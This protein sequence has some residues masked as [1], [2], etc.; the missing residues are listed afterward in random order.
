MIYMADFVDTLKKGVEKTIDGAE[1]ITKTAIKKTGETV[2]NLKINYSIKDLKSEIDKNYIELGKLLF[3]EYTEGAEFS[4]KYNEYC[5]QIEK[6]NE[7]IDELQAKLATLKNQKFC[8]E[9]GCFASSDSQFC[10]NCGNSLD[11]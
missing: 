4:G 6:Q 3:K 11:D 9:C 1:N 2:N 8:S 5:E 7:E 10:P